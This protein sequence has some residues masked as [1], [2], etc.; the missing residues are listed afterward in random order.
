[1]VAAADVRS[2]SALPALGAGYSYRRGYRVDT[3]VNQSKLGVLEIIADHFLSGS[4]ESRRELD[5]L[6]EHFTLVPH[7]LDLSLGSADGLDEAYL[8]RFAALVAR[9]RAPWWTEHVAFTRAGDV[10]I[11]HLAPL[12]FTREALDVVSRN[13]AHARRR[14]GDVPCALENIASPFVLAGAEMSEPEFLSQL[15][16]RTGCGLLL[17]GDN[18]HANVAN[19]GGDAERFMDALPPDAVVQL[20]VAGGEWIA[21]TYVDS[22][23]HAVDE[24]VWRLVESACRRFPIKAVVIERDER[25]PIFDDLLAEV[26]RAHAIGAG[27]GRWP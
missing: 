14:I 2:V 19:H 13:L 21:E 11:G 9:V 6:A 10:R 12:P 22:H 4:P 1:M 8:E 26:K 24:D 5:L 7:G 23:A 3:F 16:E 18:L 15:T 27:A 25:L 17:D 20:H